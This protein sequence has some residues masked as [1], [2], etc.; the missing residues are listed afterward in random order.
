MCVKAMHVTH[1]AHM[2]MGRS[3][4]A[5]HPMS[6]SLLGDKKHSSTWFA[7]KKRYNFQSLQEGG[8]LSAASFAIYIPCHLLGIHEL[9]R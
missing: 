9:M 7:G 3:H 8:T 1:Y 2:V 4:W 5:P 6:Q